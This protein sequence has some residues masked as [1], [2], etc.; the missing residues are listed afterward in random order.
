MAYRTQ[1]SI[2][3]ERKT[4]RMANTILSRDDPT[5]S[6]SDGRTVSVVKHIARLVKRQNDKVLLW[7]VFP[8]D[9]GKEVDN[10]IAKHY[11]NC[12]CL[13]YK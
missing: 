2:L 10:A 4:R 5:C 6:G 7:C 13:K 3:T 9:S 8:T 12:C 1:R 11:N